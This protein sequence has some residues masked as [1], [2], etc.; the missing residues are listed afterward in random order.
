VL[1]LLLFFVVDV[2]VILLL[3]LSLLLL[4]LLLTLLLL[5][6]TLLLLLSLLFV[7]VMACRCTGGA[8]PTTRGLHPSRRRR[9]GLGR[10]NRQWCR[11]H[12]I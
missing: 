10:G 9:G 6:L 5:L 7:C 12:R 1:L 8:R 4:L 11:G 3:L 2:V